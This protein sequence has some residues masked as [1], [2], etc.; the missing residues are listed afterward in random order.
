MKIALVHQ[1]H[2]AVGGT[3]RFLNALAAHLAERGHEVVIVCRRHEAAPHPRVRFERLHGFALGTS[4]RLWRFARDVERHLAGTH[5]DL[6]LG[7]GKTA[8]QDVIRAG[9]GCH[10]TYVE[11]AHRWVKQPWERGL[12]LGR[13]KN[14][15]AIA[16]ERRAYSPGAYRR[17]IAISEMVKRDL[18]ARHGVPERSI[19]VIHN[20]VDLRRFHPSRRAG[21]GTAL[22]ASLGWDPEHVVLLFLGRGFGRKGLDRLLEAFAQIAGERPQ[23]R[24]LVVGRD[25]GQPAYERQAAR[26]G[27][28]ERVRFLGE[29]GDP[30]ACY[31]AADL[32]VLPARYDAFAFSVLE[33]LATGLPVV[34]TDRT[35]ASEL[36]DESV[37]T[38]I[39]AEG[40]AA[41]L[42]AALARWLEP[43]RIERARSAAR[44]RAER[45]PF[46]RT[47][48]A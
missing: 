18:V 19:R 37:G 5:Y 40:D 8:R 11:L 29:R 31:A 14:R 16:L 32:Y 33:A 26:L 42:A 35:G 39:S 24:L 38:V 45:H 9:G 7:L 47:L 36:L 13:L 34:T 27:L 41:E 23:A 43:G 21:E 6:V 1:R 12:G 3:E 20:G 10:Q 22:R 2:A 44:A 15:L 17:V 46:E 48:Q 4:W 30:E 28:G 25:R